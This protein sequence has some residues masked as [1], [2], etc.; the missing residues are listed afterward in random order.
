MGKKQHLQWN[1]T[2]IDWSKNKE[3]DTNLYNCTWHLQIGLTVL[4]A[5][6]AN[7]LSQQKLYPNLF[8]SLSWAWL[9]IPWK[10]SWYISGSCRIPQVKDSPLYCSPPSFAQC[11]WWGLSR[12]S[13]PVFLYGLEKGTALCLRTLISH[14]ENGCQRLFIFQQVNEEGYAQRYLPLKDRGSHKVFSRWRN[15]AESIVWG[16]WEKGFG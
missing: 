4:L 11:H 9:I 14:K 16:W 12:I 15:G 7:S 10:L 13:P 2:P 1:K 5:W 3:I 6:K 8:V